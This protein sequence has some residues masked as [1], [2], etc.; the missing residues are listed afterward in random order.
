[1]TELSLMPQAAAARGLS[2]VQLCERIV[3]IATGG[4]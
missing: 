2:F 3:T 4:R 1:L